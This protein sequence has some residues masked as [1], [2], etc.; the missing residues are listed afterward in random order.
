M[1]FVDIIEKKRDGLALTQEEISFWIK[2]YVDGSIPDYQVSALCMAIYFQGMNDDEIAWLCDE[3]MHSGEIIDL[4]DIAGIKADKHS[5]GGVGDKTSLSLAP[6]VAACG[7]KVAKMSG[8]GLGHTGGT[9]DKVESIDG[10]Q[11]ALD[12]EQFKKQVNEIGLAIIGQTKQLVPADK[13]LYS[14]RDVTATVDSIPLIASS[15]MSKKLASGSDTIL[16]D[17]KF[18]DGAF[19]KTP[20]DAEKLARTMI[21]IGKKLNKDTRAMISSMDQPLGNAI[22]NALEVEE[23][24]A[25]LKNEG[26]EDFKELCMNAGAI[27]LMQGKLAE[28]EQEARAM[29]QKNIDNG[30]ALGKL[31]EMVKA[32]GGNPEQV[33]HPELLPKAK[34]QIELA[35]KKEGYVKRLKA[36]ELGTLAMQIGAGRAVKE[37]TINHAVGIVLHKKDGD[38]VEIGDSLATIHTD[39]PLS[40]E[41]IDHFYD[42]F[43][44][45]NEKVEKAPLIYKVIE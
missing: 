41:W 3:M 19:M 38:H 36:L 34:M 44:M 24:I 20:E 28:N 4:S 32:Q 16:L 18:G 6:M 14:L 12:E 37:D 33:L 27:M 11:V 1:R 39:Q 31:V 30:A 21:A 8:R 7:L 25:T 40:D 10:F 35:S 22:G 2:G 17:V 45:S 43:E 23:A 42:C 5:T 13:K 9:L 29:L 15:I 26:P